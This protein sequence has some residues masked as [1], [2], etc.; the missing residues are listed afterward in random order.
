MC[1][2]DA[3]PFSKRL[4]CTLRHGAHRH[5]CLFLKPTLVPCPEQGKASE[6]GHWGS[7]YPQRGWIGLGQD[8]LHVCC[9]M[10]AVKQCK[11][12]GRRRKEGTKGRVKATERVGTSRRQRRKRQN[13]TAAQG[14]EEARI[15]TTT[16]KKRE[17]KRGSGRR[18]GRNEGANHNER[19]E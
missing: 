19:G 16:N 15:P 1:R 12:K 5:G 8:R 7:H 2:R 6:L 18:E 14:K 11:N 3:L 4:K 13:G 17:E 10:W 9:L